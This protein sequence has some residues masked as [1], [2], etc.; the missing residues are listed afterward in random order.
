MFHQWHKYGIIQDVMAL[1]DGLRIVNICLLYN[2][3]EDQ[4]SIRSAAGSQKTGNKSFN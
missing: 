1:K 4:Q 2:A 3:I